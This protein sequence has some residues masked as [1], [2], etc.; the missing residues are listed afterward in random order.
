MHW[1]PRGAHFPGTAS[2]AWSLTTDERFDRVIGNPPFLKLHRAHRAVVEAAL[3]VPRL[4]GGN[5]PLG[6]HCWYAFVCAAVRLLR[7]GGGM[8]LVLPSAW[9]YANYAAD[10]R[11]HLPQM[12]SRFEI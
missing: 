1:R 4:G 12:F 2:L 8:C 6:S 7:P 11:E 9:D 5:V 3:R 10:L